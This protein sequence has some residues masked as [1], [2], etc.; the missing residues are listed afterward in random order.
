M[1]KKSKTGIV[2]KALAAA[3]FLVEGRGD[4]ANTPAPPPEPEI[5]KS[6]RPSRD[7]F[8][9]EGAALKKPR[10]EDPTFSR[11]RAALANS[12]IHPFGWAALKP[13]SSTNPVFTTFSYQPT[14]QT[15]PDPS[16]YKKSPQTAPAPAAKESTIPATTPE[17]TQSAVPGALT[18]SPP[19]PQ[20]HSGSPPTGADSVNQQ[21]SPK[22]AP[23]EPVLSNAASAVTEIVVPIAPVTTTVINQTIINQTPDPSTFEELKQD[24]RAI[25]EALPILGTIWK[26][27]YKKFHKPLQ[28]IWLWLGDRWFRRKKKIR[29]HSHTK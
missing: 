8:F 14:L 11:C 12:I 6:P 20:V 19:S 24:A 5:E 1:E 22:L 10:S 26:W 23:A 27:L 2:A 7:L 18:T 25:A 13:M 29:F 17:V 28:K 15:H 9:S 16:T 4:I 3:M 21:V